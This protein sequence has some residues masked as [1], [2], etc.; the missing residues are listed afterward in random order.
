MV[1]EQFGTPTKKLAILY[2]I[3]GGI[4]QETAIYGPELQS[5]KF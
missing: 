2:K 1:L 5:E 4:P 3:K